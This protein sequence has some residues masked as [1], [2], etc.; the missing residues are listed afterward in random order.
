MEY[1]NTETAEP[2]K[3]CRNKTGGTVTM[4]GQQSG[5]LCVCTEF[6]RFPLATGAAGTQVMWTGP[7]QNTHLLEYSA[8]HG[9]ATEWTSGSK[10]CRETNGKSVCPLSPPQIPKSPCVHSTES[11]HLDTRHTDAAGAH[12]PSNQKRKQRR[13]GRGR[14]RLCVSSPLHIPEPGGA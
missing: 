9:Q 6:S 8:L 13:R 3:F 2:G 14:K 10:S 12:L 5:K 4:A 11:L 1:V 7:G